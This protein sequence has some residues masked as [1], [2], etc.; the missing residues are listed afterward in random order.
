[1]RGI[2]RGVEQFIS[3]TEPIIRRPDLPELPIL[4][5]FGMGCM[6][7][8]RLQDT[9]MVTLSLMQVVFSEEIRGEIVALG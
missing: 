3:E 1:M 5:W 2:Q 6:V 4:R 9:Q 8:G 7:I